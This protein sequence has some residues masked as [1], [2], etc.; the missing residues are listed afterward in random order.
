VGVEF[1]HVQD[2]E[3]RVWLYDNYETVMHETFTPAEKVKMVQL[4]VRTE[5]MEKIL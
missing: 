4:L 1:E 3:E 2:E 5:E